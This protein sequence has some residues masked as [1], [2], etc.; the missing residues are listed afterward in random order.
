MV[1]VDR[2]VF[3]GNSHAL[4]A[5]A[6]GA[7]PALEDAELLVLAR[8]QAVGLG[9]HALVVLASLDLLELPGVVIATRTRKICGQGC[10]DSSLR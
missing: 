1:V 8:R 5:T 7:Q 6:D 2:E 10:A 3:S 4:G 9:D